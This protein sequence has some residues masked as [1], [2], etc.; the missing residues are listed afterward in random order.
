VSKVLS[1]KADDAS[2]LQD[3]SASGLVQQQSRDHG[4]A[5]VSALAFE[6]P[7][8]H[9]PVD[10]LAFLDSGE[11]A[12]PTILEQ[13]V[14]QGTGNAAKVESI[15]IDAFESLALQNNPTIAELVATTQKAAGFRTQVGLRANPT[16]G[17]DATQLA[18]QG[19][20]QHT[21][22]ISQ[23]IITA[24]KL[25]LNRQVLDEALR[26]QL[27]HL[28][29]QKYRVA[30]DVKI[31]FYEALAAQR[32]LELIQD[33]QAVSDKGLE[34]AELRKK[35]QEGSQLDV[36]QARV[37]KN[38]IDLSLQQAEVRFHAAWN[39]LAAIAGVP[40]M[41][42][43]ALEG[44]LPQ[45]GEG[46]NWESVASTT[47]A[48]SPEYQ[49]ALARVGQ[50]RA[51]LC[52]QQVQPIPNLD[53]EFASGYDNGTDNGMINL[54]V[55]APL[56]VFN[57]NQGNI[58]AARAEYVRASREVERIEDAIQARLASVSGDYEA[59]LAAVLKYSRDIIPNARE[60]LR[61]AEIAYQAGETSYIQV[62][63][64]QR[65]Y[66]DASLQFIEAQA[67]LGQAL[68]K[69]DGYLLTGA[70]DPVVDNSGDDGLRGLTLS[71]Q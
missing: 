28:E 58:G 47:L 38:E 34:F 32:R 45:Q 52:R 39:E 50:A 10:N 27:M 60:G 15:T 13:P 53:I 31:K 29:A 51:N 16:L 21:V 19:T 48:S 26:S 64:A 44:E 37:L 54:Q 1:S 20:D 57:R 41:K 62:L 12:P 70:L 42:P 33:F 11:N 36:V 23:T 56:P 25:R 3:S 40:N 8:D 9:H 35:A 2:A 71:Q 69:I 4:L 49:A 17:Y 65:M 46:M 18:D 6:E 22:F 43:V 68:A 5:Q 55:G 14:V 30:T 63:I 61:L 7:Q 24:D 66:F 67:E 59:S